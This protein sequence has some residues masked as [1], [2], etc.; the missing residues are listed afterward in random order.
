MIISLY[1]D[2]S[3]C[4]YSFNGVCFDPDKKKKG[5]VAIKCERCPKQNF[6]EMPDAEKE[7]IHPVFR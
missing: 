1:G 2:V 7:Y 6:T 5:F 3:M 4:M